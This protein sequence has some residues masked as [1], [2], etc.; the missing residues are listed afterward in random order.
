VRR[1]TK[2]VLG[3]IAAYEVFAFWYNQYGP[4]KI[5]GSGA[6]GM[7]FDLISS[8]LGYAVPATASQA[9]AFNAQMAATGTTLPSS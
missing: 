7:P 6:G 1:S 4:A 8:V 9:A 3:G 2:Y 5:G